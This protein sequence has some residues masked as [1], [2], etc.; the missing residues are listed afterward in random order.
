V[1]QHCYGFEAWSEAVLQDY[2]PPQVAALT[3]VPKATIKR[4]AREFA[5][6]SP[7]VAM[8]G[9]AVGQHTDGL[10]S[11]IDIGRIDPRSQRPFL[12]AL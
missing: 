8:G 5:G 12:W 4:L 7:T 6:T 1:S 9:E 2:A 3:G 10:A 11:H